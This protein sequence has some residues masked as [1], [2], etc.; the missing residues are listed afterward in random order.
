MILPPLFPRSIRFTL[1]LWYVGI[2]AVILCAFSAVLY[3]RVSDDLY[4]HADERLISQADAIA[5]TIFAFW[6]AEWQA[7]HE[8]SLTKQDKSLYLFSKSLQGEITRGKF[9]AFIER[10]ATETQILEAAVR[11]F[12]ILTTGGEEVISHPSFAKISP[13]SPTTQWQEAGSGL[14]LYETF[15]LSGRR[16]RFITRP[17]IENN[18]PLY[19]VQAMA[20]LRAEDDSL[21]RLRFWFMI[22][23]PG[24]L[25]GTSIVGWLLATLALRPVGKMI[26]QVQKIEARHLHERIEVPQTRDELESLAMTFNGMLKRLESSFK[27]MRQFS[28][29]ASHELRTPL[30]IVKGE[31]EVS[32]RKPREN[33]EYVRV[34]TTQ[35]GAINEIIGI[36]EQLLAL[37]RSEEGE[38]AVEWEPVDL[39][40]L[41]KRGA[42]AWKKIADSKKISLRIFENK[43]IWV[44][45]EQRLLERLLSNLLDNAIKNTPEG[46]RVEV[47]VEETGRSAHLSVQ[48]TGKGIPPEELPKIFDKFFSRSSQ[49]GS[50]DVAAGIG[51]GLGL[52]R[53]IVEA[54]QGSI[55]VQSKPGQGALFKVT[56]PL[57][58]SVPQK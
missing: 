19:I 36:V 54:H 51:L 44:R 27:R 37:A 7:R 16:I 47:F 1:T 31:L 28:A 3:D 24:I 10:W 42:A 22:L 20:F 8:G 43:K 55:E 14:T 41:T 15:I 40:E 21:K 35:L 49:H 39:G 53:W 6:Q 29:A 58:S 4:R 38:G 2:L 9:G 11:P 17:I 57:L 13:D 52:C 5:D 30:T 33:G 18:Q 48:D 56:L 23:I 26:N 32:L 46:G 25:I 45:G 50:P 12:R 34:L